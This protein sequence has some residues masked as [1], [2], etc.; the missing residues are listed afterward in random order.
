MVSCGLGHE[1]LVVHIGHDTYYAAR[2]GADVDE[3]HDRVGPH[4]VP[5]DRVLSGEQPLRRA[6]ADDHDRLSAA[7][8]VVV[9][10]A[11][12]DERSAECGK[13]ARR[14][15]PKQN[16]RIFFARALD[17]AFCG[18]LEAR[19]KGVGVTPRH[20]RTQGNAIDAGQRVDAPDRLPV[21]VDDLLGS[22]SVRHDRHVHREHALHVEA[23]LLRS[24]A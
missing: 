16:A 1:V 18:D 10:V 2:A 24:A 20:L 8:V 22:F 3:L 5:V 15:H 23:G 12:G 13:E 21:E 11:S 9:E 19:T 17:V 7:L 14:N 4:D 6:L